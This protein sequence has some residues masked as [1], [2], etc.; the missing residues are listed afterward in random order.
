[1]PPPSGRVWLAF[2]LRNTNISWALLASSIPDLIIRQGT[3]LP[4]P[5]HFKFGL[6]TALGWK[7]W[8]HRELSDMGFMGLL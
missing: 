8:V 6:G 5:I 1:M 7:E 4:V 3:S 2:C